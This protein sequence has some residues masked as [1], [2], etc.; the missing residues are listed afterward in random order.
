MTF[1]YENI[2]A[3]GVGMASA[4]KNLKFSDHAVHWMKDEGII[5][6]IAN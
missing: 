6:I 1:L 4:F 2:Q 3:Q 5:E